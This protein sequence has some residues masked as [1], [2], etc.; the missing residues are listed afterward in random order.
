MKRQ[1]KMVRPTPKLWRSAYI[2][3][4]V[5]LL[6]IAAA[7]L[8]SPSF[9]NAQDGP[10]APANIIVV[11]GP[12]PGEVIVTWDA[13]GDANFYR[14]GWLSRTDYQ[15]AG[16]DWL[17]RFAFS[18]VEGKTTYMVTRLT[19]GEYYWFIVA[20]N[21]TRYGI[22]TWPATWAP[23][24]LNTDDQ[25][26]P[27]AETTDTILPSSGDGS[28][29]SSPIPYGQE[30]QAGNFDMRILAVDEDAWP[31]I[32]SENQFNDP[33]ADGYRFVMWTIK[34][35]NQRGSVDDYEYV[36]NSSFNLVGSRGV[37]YAPYSSEN[38]CGVIPNA[39]SAS[40]YRGGSSEG[41]L[42]LAV[43]N[44]ETG[45]VFLYDTY[46][47][48]ANQESFP[49]EVWFSALPPVEASDTTSGTTS[50]TATVVNTCT[51]DD[52][53][54]DEWGD[55]PAADA[56]ATPTWTKASDDVTARDITMD[57]HVALQDAHVS[58][59][60]DW[61]ATEKSAFSTDSDNLN[62]TTRSFNSSKGSRTPD[63]LTGIAL[64]IIDADDEK[65]DYATQ[66]DEVK[67]EY[68]L[69]MTA[70]EQAT[71]NEWLALCTQ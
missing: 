68:D 28:K 35:E 33:P 47:E 6:L 57:H 61:S 23:L 65:C 71:I 21:A 12:N 11:N 30:F 8:A 46:H 18:E 42:C 55:Y 59:G 15:N 2:V 43:P 10:A 56:D 51:G 60:C 13:V 25:S 37:S 24:T 22:P 1:L 3:T 44:D 52:Y 17:E 20:S 16:D 70:S 29:R 27:A 62:P 69:G 45:F 36:S 5:F 53:D 14:I 34:V 63:Q 49:V 7:C 50:N 26:C 31:E 48:D 38:R 32:L 41:N 58:G 67:N 19:P 64:S 54:R 66:H 9:I 39:L 4:P 40:L